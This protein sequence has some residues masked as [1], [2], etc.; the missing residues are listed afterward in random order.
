MPID[1]GASGPPEFES[2]ECGPEHWRSRL[3]FRRSLVFPARGLKRSPI[4]EVERMPRQ[5]EVRG[6][7][8]WAAGELRRP[9]RAAP[10]EISAGIRATDESGEGTG[11]AA[12]AAAGSQCGVLY[13]RG[14]LG[15]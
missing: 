7:A 11:E 6:V 2:P 9:R 5:S 15:L 14:L 3:G 8:R 12:R 13:R 10:A 4:F 1:V